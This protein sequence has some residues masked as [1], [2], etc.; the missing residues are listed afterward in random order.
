MATFDYMIGR[1]RVV[2]NPR[3]YFA[4]RLYPQFDPHFILEVDQEGRRNALATR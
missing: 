2:C 4:D 1:T 3:G